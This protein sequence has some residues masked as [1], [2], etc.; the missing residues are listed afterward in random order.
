[1]KFISCDTVS[2]PKDCDDLGI[3][4]LLTVKKLINAKRILPTL[5]KSNT[6]WIRIL[7]AKVWGLAP[8]DRTY[9]S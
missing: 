4:D 8:L 1:M 7:R 9:H 5:N 6:L 3:H 2:K